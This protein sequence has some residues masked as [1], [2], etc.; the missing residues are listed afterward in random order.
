VAT[1]LFRLGALAARRRLT[2]L[3][4]ALAALAAVLVTGFGFAGDF[5]PSD[6]IPGSAAQVAMDKM[7]AHFPDSTAGASGDVVLVAP[8]G[9]QLSDPALAPQVAAVAQRITDVHGVTS[10][11]DPTETV[12]PDGSTAVLE[13]SFDVPKDTDVPAAALDGV[14]EAG[15]P[16]A[17]AGGR[18][19]YG[20]D[21]FEASHPPVGPMEGVGVGVALLVLLVTF[22]SLLAAG[23]PLL[24]AV[25]GVATTV[26]GILLAANL[27]GISDNALTL[28]VMIGLAVGIDYALLILSRHRSQ[29]ARGMSV[30]DSVA[31]ATATA[32][33]AVV[34]AGLTVVIALAGL[35]VAGVP[36]L[37]SMGLSAA[38]AVALAVAFSLLVLPAGMALMGESLRPKPGS[39][40]AR[41]EADGENDQPPLA[42]RWV[43]AVT[44]R[45]VMVVVGVIAALAAVT[46]PA[47]SLQ[48][49]LSD[50]SSAGKDTG[51]RQ[52]YDQV[53][54]ALGPGANGP[55]AVL[56]EGDTAAEVRSTAETT[57][58]RIADL[59][60]VEAVSDVQLAPD[61][62]AAVI[63][64]LPST[65]PR[66]PA[67]STLVADLRESVAPIAH[68]TG[69]YV[70]VTGQTAVSIDVADKLSAALLPFTLVVVGLS[71]V[72]LLIAFR[73][74][75][76]PL[77]ATVGFLLSVGAAFGAT[78]AVFQWGWLASLLGVPVEGPVASFVPIIVMAVLFGL[79]MDYEVFLVSA[80][81]EH[82][83]R[84]RHAHQAIRA[85]ARNA[86]RVVVAA[87]LIMVSVFASFMFSP[88]N[89]IKQI[90]FALGFGVLV[91]A[92]VVRLTLVPAV[93]ALLGDRAWSLPGWLDRI[94]PKVDVEG[95][96]VP[97]TPSVQPVDQP[98]PA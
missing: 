86:G 64:L 31:R 73:S 46:L 50:D 52:V 84:H 47:A 37:T 66:D 28:S 60:G 43:T 87:A 48:L 79:A 38:G 33:T 44:R 24:T 71:L 39:R 51:S 2:F 23:I 62:Q 11:G 19:L 35:A 61:G 75:T 94:V 6:S 26:G 41:R 36:S 20:G 96:D 8:A 68:D 27:F 15:A 18:T 70:E 10:V 97:E 83:T 95:H 40:A 90:A 22:G 65:G 3:A 21:A 56:V 59:P 76:I 63:Q 25:L 16:F 17:D 14:R 80:M 54:T 69:D 9:Q 30:A 34:F 67:T 49:A 29:L 55:L 4:S 5:E 74:W 53:A 91:D 1:F 88:D 78:V 89:D 81:R 42:T 93:L 45:P 13:V 98:V 72:L 12:S 32:G 58:A 85:G 77:K 57:A 82:Y 92:F 7:D